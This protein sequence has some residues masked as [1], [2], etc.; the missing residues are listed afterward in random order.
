MPVSPPPLSRGTGGHASTPSQALL[1]P[2]YTGLCVS[3]IL[4]MPVGM[5]DFL[6]KL[7]RP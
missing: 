7:T 2:S 3:E 4:L 6:N 1:P 5:D